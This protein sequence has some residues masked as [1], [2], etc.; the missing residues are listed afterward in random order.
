M[1]TPFSDFERYCVDLCKSIGFDAKDV[2]GAIEKVK[3]NSEL[4]DRYST[5]TYEVSAGDD[6]FWVIDCSRLSTFLGSPNSEPAKIVIDCKLYRRTD[7]PDGEAV[8]IDRAHYDCQRSGSQEPFT[9]T[10]KSSRE[11]KYG[12]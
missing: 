8:C 12:S 6:Y 4:T 5:G 9:I 2:A 3:H 11:L 10:E 7:G 1:R